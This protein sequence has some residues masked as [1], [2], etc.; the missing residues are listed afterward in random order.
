MK[1][2]VAILARDNEAEIADCLESVSWADERYVILDTRSSDQT[3]AIARKMGARVDRH[4]FTNFATQRDFALDNAQ[5]EWIFFLDSDERAT[6]ELASEVRQVISATNAQV[7]WW[8][9]RYNYIWGAVVKHGGWYPDYQLRLIKRGYGHYDPARQVHEVVLLD[10]PEGYLVQPLIHHNYATLGQFIRKQRQ[11]VSLEADI[12][13]KQGVRPKPWTYL[14]LPL[15]EFHRRYFKLQGYRDGGRG[16]II[17]AL[18]AYYYG[19]VVTVLLAR[20]L[21][22]QQ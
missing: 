3:E 19:F 14:S 12:R 1:L 16:F 18:V 9:P 2:T 22:S 21:N 4:P 17:C 5:Q 6:P 11:Y 7:G 20:R 15:R 10:G 13:H 8:V